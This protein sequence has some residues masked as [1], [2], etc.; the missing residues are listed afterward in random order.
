[1]LVDSFQGVGAIPIDVQDLNADFVTG[2][3]LKYLLGSSGLAFLYCRADL[4]PQITPTVT[5]WFADEDIFKM[6]IYDYSPSATARKFE[7]GTP[8]IPNIYAGNAG[9]DLMH[10]I[11]IAATERHVGRLTAQLIDGLDRIGAKMVTPR[12]PTKRGPMVAVAT[13]DEQAMVA[14][15]KEDGILTSARDGNIRLSFHC[16]NS[17]EDIESV[18]AGLE[19]HSDML[20]R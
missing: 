12:D 18:V 16:Y 15:L 20:V 13:T 1:M 2:G 8:P 7:S 6:D 9:M 10:E 19:K 3:V 4:L 17:E 11:G 5:G 14:A